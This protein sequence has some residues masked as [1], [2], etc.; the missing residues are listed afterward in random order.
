MPDSG[1]W[2]PEL[3][4]ALRHHAIHAIDLGELRGLVSA[5]SFHTAAGVLYIA[6][7]WRIRQL[8]WPVLGLNAAMLIATPVEGTHYLADMLLG[9]LVAAVALSSSPPSCAR[10]DQWPSSKSALLGL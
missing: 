1:L 8:R 3:I 4:P 7:A 2:Q 5:P 9:A 6:T 10:P